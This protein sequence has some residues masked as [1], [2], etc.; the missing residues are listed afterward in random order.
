MAAE[1]L[2]LRCVQ[3]HKIK[4]MLTAKRRWR[5]MKRTSAGE[6]N[7]NPSPPELLSLYLFIL[8]TSKVRLFLLD[9]RRGACPWE[10]EP[11]MCQL[12]GCKTSR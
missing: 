4:K 6:M 12:A 8:C 7:H 2:W 3:G 5:P 9:G 1:L 10:G 11:H